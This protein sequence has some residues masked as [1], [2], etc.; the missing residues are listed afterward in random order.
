MT[1]PAPQPEEPNREAEAARVAT[2][3]AAHPRFLAER[4]GL[5]RALHPPQRVHGENL[6]DHMAAL[7]AA[8]RAETGAVAEVARGAQDLTLRAA[9]AVT[10]LIGA[11]DPL[12]V[13][14]AEWPD[15][16]GLES[17]ALAEEGP[18]SPSLR[19]LPDGAIAR[20]TDG[21]E[22]LLRD[23]PAEAA[24]LHGEAH[25]LITRDALAL[26]PGSYP[27]LL[28]LGAREAGRLPLRGATAPLRLLAHALA[29]ALDTTPGTSA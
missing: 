3:L 13:V 5:Y 1:R 22:V 9:L 14:S 24:L 7:L 16:L 27:R 25:P 10:A 26:L 20:L 11:A 4:P 18:P 29:R 15:L 6:A 28:V 21:R 8:A 17:A 2:Y 23:A 12:A 19:A